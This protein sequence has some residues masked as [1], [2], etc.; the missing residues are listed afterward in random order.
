MKTREQVIAILQAHK[1]SLSQRWPISSL[2]LFGSVA[3]GD[4]REGSDV[5]LLIELKSAMGWDFFNLVGELEALLECKVDLV[6]RSQI[7][8]KAWR[9]IE[10]EIIDV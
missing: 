3:R 8:P 9:Y 1:H 6:E 10:Q 7:K 5:D 4:Q 2:S